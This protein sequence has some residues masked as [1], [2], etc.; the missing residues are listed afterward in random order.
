MLLVYI[1]VCKLWVFIIFLSGEMYKENS[2]GLSIDFWGILYI[3][4]EGVDIVWL[5]IIDWVWL[6]R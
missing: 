4:L 3:R 2:S 5:I 1:I 6:I